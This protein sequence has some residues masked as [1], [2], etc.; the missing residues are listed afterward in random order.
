MSGV[1]RVGCRG[2]RRRL[3]SAL[4]GAEGKENLSFRQV[5]ERVA[6][7]LGGAAGLL[8]WVR[9]SEKNEQ[10]F[11]CN[12]FP[13]LLAL[14]PDNEPNK[15]PLDKKAQEGALEKLRRLVEGYTAA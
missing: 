1:K 9:R 15:P 6:E 8:A 7:M 10:L 13:K 2:Q 3:K 5:V 11:W 12:I 14:Q 4:R